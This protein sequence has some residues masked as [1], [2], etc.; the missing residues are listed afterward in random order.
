LNHRRSN[1]PTEERR[2]EPSRGPATELTKAIRK[3]AADGWHEKALA[4]NGMTEDYG[5]SGLRL[6]GPESFWSDK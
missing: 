6:E 1:P 2:Q 5:K 4:G 3:L